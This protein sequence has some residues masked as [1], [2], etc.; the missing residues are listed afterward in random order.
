MKDLLRAICKS[1]LTLSG[2]VGTLGEFALKLYDD[3]LSEKRNM[4]LVA[5]IAEGSELTKEVVED[6]FELQ[7]ESGE[8]KNQLL[9]GLHTVLNLIIEKQKEL[10]FS[11]FEKG[12]EVD[13]DELEG[14][15]T[16]L[17][18][19]HQNRLTKEG[20]IT[21]QELVREL[22]F[23]YSD[24]EH[25]RSV[26][27]GAGFPKRM[28]TRRAPA[29]VAYSEFIRDCRALTR[30]QRA[31]IFGALAKD[32]PGSHVINTTYTL[33]VEADALQLMSPSAVHLR[34]KKCADTSSGRLFIDVSN[35]ISVKD[36]ASLLKAVSDLHELADMKPPTIES[37]NFEH[38]RER[39]V[40]V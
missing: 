1:L 35:D 33:L 16:R 17:I 28:L 19:Q 38:E 24:V 12:E 8:M 6:I 37:I 39:D 13:A 3:E 7:K 29:R 40:H 27:Y 5:R 31:D 11:V 4:A 23:L 9:I 14:V 15:I 18:E 34:P 25:F 22:A 32:H 36:L 2:P 26:V 20:F 21:E 30:K 10:K